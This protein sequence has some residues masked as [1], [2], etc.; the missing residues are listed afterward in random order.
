[1]K[2]YFLF[3]CVAAA[4]ASCTSDEFLGEHQE[5][6]KNDLQGAILFTSANQKATRAGNHTGY[7]AAKLLNN[8]F[9]VM[10]TKGGT[11]GTPS[12]VVT[13]TV[14]DHYNVK[15]EANT[16]HT[17]ES[18]TADWEYVGETPH[19]YA[20][21]NG[22]SA[23]TIKYWDYSKGQYDFI[24][25][26]GGEANL[27]YDAAAAGKLYVTEIDPANATTAA[28]TVTGAAADLAKFYIADLVTVPQAKFGNEV[29]I[30]FRNLAAKVRVG[31]YET[32]PGY[33]I[34]DVEFYASDAA[35]ATVSSNKLTLYSQSENI[36]SDGEYTVFYP[37]VNKEGTDLDNN[38]AHL[39][40]LPSS[41]GKGSTSEYAALDYIREQASTQISGE[42][43][44]G[45]TSN[46]ATYA[47]SST[48]KPFTTVLPNETATALTLRVN[49]T[50]VSN[51]GSKETIKV[52]GAKAVVP[53][54]YTQ[55]KSNYAYTYLFKISDK[56]NGSTEKLGGDPT[57]E[58]LFPITFDAIVV[59]N[60]EGMQETV[61]TVATPSITTYMKE[62][63]NVTAK[64]EYPAGKAIYVMVQDGATL[65]GDLDTKGQLYTINAEATEALV[66]D[67]LNMG[68][69][70]GN[71]TT[72]RNGV[73]LTKAT[74]D[75]TITTIPGVD[76]NNIG[77]TKG[78]AASF[79]GSAGYYAYVYTVDNT[80][81]ATT[82]NTA[83]KPATGT[84]VSSGY[85][86]DFECT[87]AA[88]GTAD[89]STTYYQKLTNN[90][91]VY[92][93]KVIKVV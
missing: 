61:T 76:G 39:S 31:L 79:T 7:D 60:E 52:W 49:Y 37:T 15:W 89:G 91:V 93:V 58:G 44:L 87:V 50:L 59:D 88:T 32:V 42:K 27:V 6:T 26:S 85:Y 77:I 38:K 75:A 47:G 92:A 1:M 70:A 22:I 54:Q 11:I 40:F 34:K 67:A 4:F 55:W 69:T 41:T 68:T 8:H 63:P 51:D 36:Y 90:N 45:E 80:A 84:D 78:Q 19:A 20:T 13:T 35:T 53:A 43:Y 71:V 3:A 23:Q 29:Q 2:K 65:K 73:V 57:K 33:S 10:G 25:Y 81:A 62:A 48:N 17:T 21:A 83:V 9:V 18:N 14:F 64:N 82:Y 5:L 30:K 12:S 56:T 24:A 16:A 66:M 72:G 46:A 28:Y 86:T 74:S